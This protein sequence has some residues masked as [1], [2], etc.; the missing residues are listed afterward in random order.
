MASIDIGKVYLATADGATERYLYWLYPGTAPYRLRPRRLEL[1]SASEHRFDIVP[2]VTSHFPLRLTFRH[3]DPDTLH[4]QFANLKT[5][6]RQHAPL[7]FAPGE[8][9]TT[10][11]FQVIASRAT[12]RPLQNW[13]DGETAWYEAELEVYVV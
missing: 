8:W 7:W 9:D 11:A 5:T 3:T 4:G 6:L 12:I 13:L 2:W 10:D 1:D